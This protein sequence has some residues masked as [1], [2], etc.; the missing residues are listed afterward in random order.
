MANYIKPHWTSSSLQRS[1]RQHEARH[2]IMPIDEGI[3]S[4]EI[5]KYHDLVAIVQDRSSLNRKKKWFEL[6]IISD[7]ARAYAQKTLTHSLP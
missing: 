5:G 7:I 6:R 4:E 3:I 1:I 2:K